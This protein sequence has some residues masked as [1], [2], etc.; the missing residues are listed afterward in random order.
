VFGWFNVA[1]DPWLYAV[2]SGLSLIG[3][4]G[5]GLQIVRWLRD[6]KAERLSDLAW[7]A[8]WV[9][10][11][12][13][14]LVGWS[15][16]RYP[17]GRLLFP[18]L[19]AFSVLLVAGLSHVSS[20]L[21][22]LW[23]R[24]C[25][26]LLA[27][28]LL[29]LAVWAPFRYIAPAYAAV[30]P[31]ADLPVD[32]RASETRF[33]EEAQLLGY[34][35]PQTTV[36]P[37]DLLPVTLYW[38]AT[39]TM[40]TD[41]SVFLHLLD[42]HGLIVAQRDSYPGGGALLTSEWPIGSVIE[43]R[44][45]IQVPATALAPSH[46]TLVVGLYDF[47]TSTRL[48]T[49]DGSDGV[50][51]GAVSVLPVT[52][53]SGVPNPVYFDFEEKLALVGFDLDRSVVSPGEKLHLTLYWRALSSMAEDYT[54]F[55]H[56]LLPTGEVWAQEDAQPQHGQAPTSTWQPG[57]TIEDHYELTPPSAAPHGVYEIEVGLYLLAT[58][59][60]LRVGLSDEGIVLGKVR[61][62]E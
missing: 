45:V 17:Q 1:A 32:V 15:R 31:I 62:G 8:L 55:T 40:Q 5:L 25:A 4:V 44:H 50:A 10:T 3:L 42:S 24:V 12:L 27:V 52:D 22:I 49:G 7:L 60:R 19:S 14:A 36:R 18:A 38:R 28:G 39:R 2:Y 29:A 35:L 47:E 9:L 13:V 56:L 57:Q 37:G 21:S 33:A 51:L 43:D 61:V 26:L 48:P 6:R 41:Y 54:V 11:V 58:G 20:R 23:R 16:K 46:T 53:S 59:D 30:Q 34:E